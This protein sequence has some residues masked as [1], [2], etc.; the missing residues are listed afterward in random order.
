MGFSDEAILLLTKLDQGRADGDGWIVLEHYSGELIGA[1][2]RN[3]HIEEKAG[4]RPAMYRITSK[5]HDA[6]MKAVSS[7]I[8][9]KKNGKVSALFQNGNGLKPASSP[10]VR[11]AP[12]VTAPINTQ[13]A[14]PC[15]TDGCDMQCVYRQAVDI[16]TA[17]LPGV[18]EL[19][20]ALKTIDGKR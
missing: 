17:K 9:Q 19:V 14:A 20:D 12:A 16:L 5:G 18:R 11:P 10:A 7:P 1:M 2:K 6:L 4:C 3:K 8:K 15:K 13:N